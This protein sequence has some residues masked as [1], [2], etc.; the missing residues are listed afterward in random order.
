MQFFF[1]LLVEHKEKLLRSGR[2]EEYYGLAPGSGARAILF[3][4]LAPAFALCLEGRF[5]P[6]VRSP[7]S[8]SVKIREIC[9]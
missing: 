6:G 3:S 2:G 7:F 5:G 4:S 8:L 9:G 1:L